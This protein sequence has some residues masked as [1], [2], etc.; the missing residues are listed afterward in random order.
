M[1]KTLSQWLATQILPRNE[2]RMLLQHIMGYTHAQLITHDQE[3]L[4]EQQINQLNILAK[5]R[6]QGEPMAYLLGTREFYGRKFTVS[7]AVLIPRPET[8][9]LLEAALLRLPEMVCCGI[10]VRGAVFWAF[11]PNWNAKI[12]L[13]LQVI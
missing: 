13:F 5:R 1:K 11:L 12:V 9:H 3:I 6:E 10:W 4:T 7:P 2:S 8:E